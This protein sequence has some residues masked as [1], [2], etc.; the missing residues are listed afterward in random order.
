MEFVQGET[1]ADRI[2]RGLRCRRDPLPARSR[3]CFG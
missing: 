1:L 2:T 3:A